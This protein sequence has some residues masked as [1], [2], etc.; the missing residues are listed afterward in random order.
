MPDLLLSSNPY[1]CITSCGFVFQCFKAK[2]GIHAPTS[3]HKTSVTDFPNSVPFIIWII[4][5]PISLHL[6]QPYQNPNC[7]CWDEHISHLIQMRMCS[8]HPVNSWP[9]N[10]RP[11]RTRNLTINQFSLKNELKQTLFS[12]Y[13][14]LF[15]PKKNSTT[16]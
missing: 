1:T 13:P 16:K 2:Y 12:F 9:R 10:K 6:L 5:P 11:Q 3:K 4:F 7:I 8:N 15:A 14:S